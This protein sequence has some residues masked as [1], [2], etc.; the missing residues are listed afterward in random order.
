MQA[1]RILALIRAVWPQILEVLEKL[2]ETPDVMASRIQ[3]LLHSSADAEWTGGHLLEIQVAG[4]SGQQFLCLQGEDQFLLCYP[5]Q[6]ANLTSHP[7]IRELIEEFA[8]NFE[9]FKL[10]PY[11]TC[12][13]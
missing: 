7:F 3:D 10:D 13:I 11:G 2:W 9:E 8:T 12:L 4:S 6:N 1:D 5:Q